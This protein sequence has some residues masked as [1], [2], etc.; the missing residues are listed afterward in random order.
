MCL[1]L[2]VLAAGCQQKSEIREYE[3]T[4]ES[5]EI[6]TTDVLRDQFQPFPF[7]WEVPAHWKES[8]NDQFSQFAWTAGPSG[9][10]A[11]ITVSDLPE[12]AGVEPQFVRWQGQLSLPE[13]AAADL[14]RSVERVPIGRSV[15]QWVEINGENET[16][17][18]MIVP[19]QDKLWVFK[20]RSVNGTAK[21]ERD[22]FRTFCESLQAG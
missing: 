19:Y 2:S 17:L 22:G 3:V 18:G 6:L 1:P 5:T 13:S 21:I 12:S 8:P 4:A 16:I 7:D 15:G 14:L 20:Y 10:E 9:K 11:R